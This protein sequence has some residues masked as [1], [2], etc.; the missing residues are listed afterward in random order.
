ESTVKIAMEL[1]EIIPIQLNGT[2]LVIGEIK[3]ILMNPS[4]VGKDGYVDHEKAGTITVVGLDSY[5]DT[6]ALA[7]LSYAKPDEIVKTV[8]PA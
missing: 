2:T 5:F 8:T 6:L 1:R 3:H 7:R 4:L